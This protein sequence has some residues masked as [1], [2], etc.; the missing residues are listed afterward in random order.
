MSENDEDDANL[1][2]DQLRAHTIERY[3]AD[4][5]AQSG[6]KRTVDNEALHSPAVRHSEWNGSTNTKSEDIEPTGAPGDKTL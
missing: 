1:M 6:Q 2:L 4:T 5:S 3:R